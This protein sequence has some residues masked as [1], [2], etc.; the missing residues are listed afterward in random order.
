MNLRKLSL[1]ALSF[2]LVSTASYAGDV[3][4][5]I[6]KRWKL[7]KETEGGKEI[8]PKH[9]RLVIE[10]EKNGEFIIEAAYEETHK[11]TYT[12]S[13]DKKSVILDDEISKEKKTL[14]I[15]RIDKDH[16]NLG[17]FDGAT[18]VVEMVPSKKNEDHLTNRELL[19]V[20]KWHCHKSDEE[21]NVEMVIEFHRDHTYVIIP[22]G[23]K[24]PT[25]YGDWKLD[26]N[27][28]HKILLEIKAK[29]Q[30]GEHLELQIVGEPQTH[31]LVLKNAGEDGITNHF[32]DHELWEKY[33]SGKE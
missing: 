2:V 18:T 22:R 10:F 20:N 28:N 16:L 1:L 26:P 30:K 29:G 19:I 23:S 11:G 8:T 9:E 15:E 25:V 32:R 5:L 4:K 31:E 14:T 13:E 7:V 27:D 17:G 21:S 12:I 24:I 3:S 33:Q 6:V